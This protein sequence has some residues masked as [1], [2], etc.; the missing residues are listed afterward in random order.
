MI[1]IDRS[2]AF[3]VIDMKWLKNMWRSH[4]VKVWSFGN[5]AMCIS[6][7]KKLRSESDEYTRK[8]KQIKNENKKQVNRFY[9]L[10]CK[11][12]PVIQIKSIQL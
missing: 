6:S 1:S 5:V 4:R 8:E 10:K 11:A 12:L 2:M 3:L 9:T 7:M